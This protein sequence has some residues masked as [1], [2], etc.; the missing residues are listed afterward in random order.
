MTLCHS[1]ELIAL[2]YQLSCELHPKDAPQA[3]LRTTGRLATLMHVAGQQISSAQTE[4]GALAL[5]ARGLSVQHGGSDRTD[6]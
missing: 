5:V 1:Q 6:H 2:A 3:I 4:T